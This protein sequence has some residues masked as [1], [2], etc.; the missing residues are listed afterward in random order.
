MKKLFT[1]MVMAMMLVSASAQDEKIP[2]CL[3]RFKNNS[4]KGDVL[5]N[6]LRSVIADGLN[7]SRRL[8]LVDISTLGKVPSTKNEMLKYINEKG[9]PYLIEGS[10]NA[11][12]SKKDDDKYYSAEVNYSITLIDTETGVTKASEAYKG[13]SNT[14]KSDEEAITKAIGS[15]ENRMGKFV[16]VYFK[17]AATIKELGLVDVKKGVKTCYISIGS[18]R[19]I[20]RGQI[21]EVFAKMEVAGEQIDKKIGE[22]K[23]SEVLSPTL[24]LCNV[25]KGG[26]DIQRNYE[27]NVPMKVITRPSYWF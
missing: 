20:A 9:I 16:D 25:K 15:A 2:V 11:V 24:T 1:L 14:G 27:N 19:G 21:L 23:V 22:L 5:L 6:T 12:T 3:G 26:L 7:G 8:A 18:A 13:T 10:L 17:L 4:N